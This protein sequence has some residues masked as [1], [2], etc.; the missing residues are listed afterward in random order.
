MSKTAETVLKIANVCIFWPLL[1][2]RTFS[3]N[4]APH[5]PQRPV[6]RFYWI[7]VPDIILGNTTLEKFTMMASK[8]AKNMLFKHFKTKMCFRRF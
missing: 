3:T 1:C 2:L 6:S 8:G 5:P 4:F 7:W